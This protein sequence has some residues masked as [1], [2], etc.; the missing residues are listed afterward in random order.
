[1]TKK[2][3]I[4]EGLRALG[5][6][7]GPLNSLLA[8]VKSVNEDEKTCVIID[9]DIEINDVRLSPVINEKESVTIFP[10][11]GSW[12]LVVRIEDDAEWMVIATEEIDKIRFKVGDVVFEQTSDGVLIKK[13]DDTLKEIL[14]L[15]I[16]SVQKIAVIYGSNPDFVKLTEALNKTNNLLQ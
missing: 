11:E 14:Q 6:S 8:V 10:K 7:V 5:G 2:Q 9:D 12:V 16:Q 3:Q 13:D 1:M 15:I 4:L